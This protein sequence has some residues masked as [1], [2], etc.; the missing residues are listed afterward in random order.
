ML[1]ASPADY[2]LSPRNWGKRNFV[3]VASTIWHKRNQ[4]LW[5][6]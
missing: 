5:I 1:S 4:C 6:A 2:T 3:L